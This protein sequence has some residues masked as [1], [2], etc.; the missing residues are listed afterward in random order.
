MGKK[1]PKNRTQPVTKPAKA[2]SK[3]SYDYA[4]FK[5][6]HANTFVIATVI[7]GCLLLFSVLKNISYPLFWADESMTAIGTERVLQF[8]YPKV[9]DG[10][11]VFYDLRH[12]NPTLGINEKD[13]AYVGGAGWGQYYFGIAGYK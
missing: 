13:D 1:P 11:N 4:D 12:S 9:H 5:A 2:R 6:K 7:L 10:K 8:G 3:H